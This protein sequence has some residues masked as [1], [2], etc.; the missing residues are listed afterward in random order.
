MA[1]HSK[2]RTLSELEVACFLQAAAALR[3]VCCEPRIA[4]SSEHAHD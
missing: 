3:G 2:I 1:R 4:A